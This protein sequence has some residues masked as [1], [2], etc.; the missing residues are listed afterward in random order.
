M[1]HNCNENSKDP[2]QPVYVIYANVKKQIAHV[3]EKNI[4]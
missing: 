1:F 4:T 3:L 2:L